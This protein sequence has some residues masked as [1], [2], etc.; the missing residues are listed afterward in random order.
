MWRLRRGAAG[1]PPPR[2]AQRRCCAA[3]A[4]APA[5]A[6]PEAHAK[7]R[8]WAAGFRG[9]PTVD[10]IARRL[11]DTKRPR[12]AGDEADTEEAREARRRE[13]AECVSELIRRRLP[14]VRIIRILALGRLVTDTPDAAV[15]LLLVG[16]QRQWGRRIDIKNA[17][18]LVWV[19][20]EQFARSILQAEQAARSVHSDSGS[21]RVKARRS[22]LWGTGSS[23]VALLQQLNQVQRWMR[24]DRVHPDSIFLEEVL[25]FTNALATAGASLSHHSAGDSWAVTHKTRNLGVW[26]I[27]A[28]CRL[29]DGVRADY[30]ALGTAPGVTALELLVQ[31]HCRGR[32]VQRADAALLELRDAMRED[33]PRRLRLLIASTAAA[34][35][36]PYF[37]TI[38][39]RWLLRE[40]GMAPADAALIPLWYS[41]GGGG[42][43][44]VCHHRS[45]HRNPDPATVEEHRQSSGWCPVEK[46]VVL[47]IPVPI[48]L[49]RPWNRDY[50]A[51]AG[52]FLDW[53]RERGFELQYEALS[54]TLGMV[55]AAAPEVF[56]PMCARLCRLGMAECD[57][58]VLETRLRHC[59]HYRRR[60]E[61]AEAVAAVAAPAAPHP[62]G[63]LLRACADALQV[64]PPAERSELAQLLLLK[65]QQHSRAGA[66]TDELRRMAEGGERDRPPEASS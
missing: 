20:S 38:W 29:A 22:H 54:R 43:C 52:A 3:P 37:P 4:S 48:A 33:P 15:A 7:L 58:R 27:A 66:A 10:S 47:R 62:G 46:E 25:R 55:A 39:A 23:P 40:G 49:P 61:V 31:I 9:G 16:Y 51:E 13:V 5:P 17:S 65:A 28:A 45:A 34:H 1:R 44:M 18:T 56:D 8:Q 50:S 19:L 41:A 32:D 24:E 63:R 21:A 6:G 42:R 64:L 35:N 30:D 53:C 2:R 57:D 11:R 26:C 36:D 59:A 12:D 14:P 60:T